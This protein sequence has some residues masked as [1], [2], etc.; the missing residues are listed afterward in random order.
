MTETSRQQA[1]LVEPAAR[2]PPGHR[3]VPLLAEH[4]LEH[5]R[6]FGD[7]LASTFGLDSD[8]FGPPGL[9]SVGGRFY[10]LVFVGYS[11]RRS[12]PEC[13][14]PPWYPAWSRSTRSKPTSTCG[15]SRMADRRRG[16][17]VGRRGPSRHRTHLPGTWRGPRPPAA[18]TPA[19]RTPRRSIAGLPAPTPK[20]PRTA[21][22]GPSRFDGTLGPAAS[23][24][25]TLGHLTRRRRYG[26]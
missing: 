5:Y 2:R 1:V 22:G 8:P 21:G 15:R 16:R 17:R 20:V 23:R 13:A 12:L 11:A 19:T 6:E 7:F 18:A 14:S 25:W 3:S 9:L 10:E 4:Q 26:L 24:W